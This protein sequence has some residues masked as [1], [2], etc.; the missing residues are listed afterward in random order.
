LGR[1]VKVAKFTPAEERVLH[2]H[3]RAVL[4]EQKAALTKAAETAPAAKPEPQVPKISAECP[5][6]KF[7]AFEE[8]GWMLGYICE[9]KGTTVEQ[10]LGKICSHA[11]WKLMPLE[12]LC[13]GSDKDRTTLWMYLKNGMGVAVPHQKKP[14]LLGVDDNA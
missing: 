1:E 10:E 14:N 2:G 11:G 8:C 12:L 9:R 6:V 13:S 4:E 3:L 5:K 7:D